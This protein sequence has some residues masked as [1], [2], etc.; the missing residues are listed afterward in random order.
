MLCGPGHD[1]CRRR[2]L[3]SVVEQLLGAKPTGREAMLEKKRA[4]RERNAGG[5]DSPDHGGSD[6]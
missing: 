4:G 6:V 1:R 2:D 5:G 3:Q